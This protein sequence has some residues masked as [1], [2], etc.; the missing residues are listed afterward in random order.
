MNNNSQIVR[1]YTAPLQFPCG[2]GTTCCSIGQSDEYVSSLAAAIE[3]L[4]VTVKLHNVAKDDDLALRFPDATKLLEEFG[5]GITPIL[6]FND[7]LAAMGLATIE[8]AVS[9]IRE[10]L[11]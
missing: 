7:E 10:R 3:S 2:E 6:S 1:I 11:N 5:H 4:G 9:V 8:E